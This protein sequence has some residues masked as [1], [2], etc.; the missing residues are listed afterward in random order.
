M[1]KKVCLT[2]ISK[3]LWYQQ[4]TGLTSENHEYVQY[5]NFH[6]SQYSQILHIYENLMNNFKHKSR[7]RIRC[8]R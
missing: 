5:V 4:E 1:L 3:I 8:E 7:N 2:Q 6:H